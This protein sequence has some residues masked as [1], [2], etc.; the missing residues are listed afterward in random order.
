M[1][2]G[3]RDYFMGTGR[4]RDFR[5]ENTVAFG[6]CAVIG[7]NVLLTCEKAVSLF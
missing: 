3:Y 6:G 4:V 7:Q 5:T 1:A 2:A